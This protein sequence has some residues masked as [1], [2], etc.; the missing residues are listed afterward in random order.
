MD[1]SSIMIGKFSGENWTTWKFQ[2]V[3]MLKSKGLYD[4]VCGDTLKPTTPR[5]EVEKWDRND[6]KAQEIIVTRM[7]EKQLT[8]I[9]ACRTAAEMWLKL[10]TI[11]EH[12]SQVSV[13]LLQQRF[14]SLEYK[15]GSV[16]QFIS[17]IE[18]I[19]STLKGL[20]EEIS[21]KMV[22]TKILISLPENL[23]HFVSAWES[24]P[25]DKQTMNEL[26]SRL[27]IEEERMNKSEVITALTSKSNEVK[28]KELRCF[29]CNKLGHFKKQCQKFRARNFNK[30]ICHYCKKEG[31][32]IQNCWL[33]NKKNQIDKEEMNQGS[34]STQAFVG[35]S[36]N[37]NENVFTT[38]GFADQNIDTWW[39]D[40]GATEH[41][42]FNQ[43]LFNEINGLKIKKQVKV[44]NGTL[45]EVRGTGNIKLRS[46]NGQ[47]W[48]DTELKNVFF[49]PELKVNLFSV[50]SALDKGFILQSNKEKCELLDD[51]GNVRAVAERQGKMFKMCFSNFIQSEPEQCNKVESILNWH[52]KLAHVNFEQVKKILNNHSIKYSKVDNPFCNDCLAGKQHRLPFPKSES[53]AKQTC[54]LI[55]SD[56]CG[57]FEVPSLGGSKYYLLLKDDFSGYRVVYFLKNKSETREKIQ[58]F[59]YMAE[60][61]TNNKVKTMRT[62]NGLEFINKELKNVFE[63]MGIRHERTCTYSPEQNG[64][65]ERENRTL[66]EAARTLLHS[67]NQKKF[68]WAEAINSAVFTLNRIG[69]CPIQDQNCYK[70]WFGKDYDINI[71]NE[72]GSNVAVHVPKE[73]RLK[74]DSKTEKGIFVGYSDVTKGYRIFFPRTNKIEVHRDVIFIPENTI[75]GDIEIEPE[76]VIKLNIEEEQN[77]DN[78]LI[79]NEIEQQEQ[80]SEEINNGRQR[81]K[82]IWTKDYEMSFYTATEEPVTYEDAVKGKNAEEWKKAIDSELCVL[83]ENNT[84]SEVPWPSDKKVIESKWVFKV[85]NEN[86]FKA[87]LVARG[88]QQDCS[89]ELYDIYAPVAKLA[90]FRILIVIANKLGKPIFQM[91]VRSAFLYGDISEEVYMSLPGYNKSNSDFVCKLHKSIYGL[92]KSPRCWNTKFDNL[93]KSEGFTRSQNDFCL[94]FKCSHPD[95]LFVLLYVDDLLIL[96][97]DLQKVDKL[98]Y[99]FSKNFCMKDLGIVS[100]YLGIH[101]KQ[102]LIEGYTVLNQTRYLK[103][104]LQKFDMSECKPIATPLDYN[105][106]CNAL[107]DNEN[108]PDLVKLCRQII[109]N[110]MYAAL[111]TR[112]D[113]CQSVNLLSRYQDKSNENLYK[114]L[115]RIL[116]YI[117]GTIALNLL[118]KPNFNDNTL[119][120]YVDADWGGDVVE[121][122]STTGYIFKFFGCT[123]S[124]CSKKQQ[125][126]SISSTES[127]YVALS[128]AICE[129]CWLRK[130]I[131]DFDIPFNCPIV[132]YEDNQ[133]AINIAYNPENNKRL[134]H[135]DIKHFF[136][137][138]KIDLGLINVVHMNTNDQ[139]ADMFTKILGRVKF[140]KF[141][142][143][144]NLSIHLE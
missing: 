126:V 123:I 87:R 101:V 78:T 104:V 144:L 70:L 132:L 69:N 142:D 30:K 106:N 68:L 54:E 121:R 109:G 57:P 103:N 138:E 128:L 67:K 80:E 72:F 31:H 9:L 137:K 39:L 21:E 86:E 81:R 43:T 53:R 75:K 27:L 117:K 6:A 61:Q 29:L 38:V 125:N 135:I 11:Y 139:V 60:K 32:I 42:C 20:G 59:I 49:V 89:S 79:N 22:I 118:F 91:D 127:E 83:H 8:H 96:G 12:K 114:A 24:T 90:T 63:K 19:Q 131:V 133:S 108:N 4:L 95:R 56:L 112:P 25:N 85:K 110:L 140:E 105:M 124:W 47:K 33:K 15:E 119:Y 58:S 44:G 97:T 64:R 74:L 66:V 26:M 82:P 129:A 120:G 77:E 100:H 136:I 46:W 36:I 3:V 62:D 45:L 13:H 34:K 16:A 111:G 116:R 107:I 50:S 2:V 37:I 5:T 17:E 113:L 55:H 14:F 84:W 130:I 73:K 1:N 41:M 35:T 141:R 99:S 122:K 98:K 10:Q 65:A 92:K 40:S 76:N 28:Q 115:K 51:K 88:F 143:D 23:K 71:F 102:N 7:E 94:Y 93:M 18:E 48:L 52:K 134:K